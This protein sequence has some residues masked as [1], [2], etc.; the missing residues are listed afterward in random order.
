MTPNKKTRQN[1]KIFKTCLLIFLSSLK[2]N[3]VS[4]AGSDVAHASASA[5]AVADTTPS[6][7][8]NPNKPSKKER[9]YAVSFPRNDDFI[10]YTPFEIN[11]NKIHLQNISNCYNCYNILFLLKLDE[12]ENL[13]KNLTTSEKNNK[14]IAT[15]FDETRNKTSTFSVIDGCSALIFPNDENDTESIIKVAIRLI[16]AK[17]LDDEN[18][19]DSSSEFAENN[20][21]VHFK[22]PK[23]LIEGL[24]KN[25]HK[26][27]VEDRYNLIKKYANSI[28]ENSQ[29]HYKAAIRILLEK[30]QLKK[31]RELKENDFSSSDV[32]LTINLSEN[33]NNEK[34]F[35]YVV[36]PHS[37]KKYLIQVHKI[38][39]EDN[40]INLSGI[41]N[42]ISI[43]TLNL[44][45][46]SFEDIEFKNYLQQIGTTQSIENISH[47]LAII[48]HQTP[49][50]KKINIQITDIAL[51][52]AGVQMQNEESKQFIFYE[53]LIFAINKKTY[54]DFDSN[55]IIDIRNFINQT[56]NFDDSNDG[57]LSQAKNFLYLKLKKKFNRSEAMLLDN[58]KLETH[59]NN[60]NLRIGFFKNLWSKIKLFFFKIKLWFKYSKDERNEI[61]KLKP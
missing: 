58:K 33:K 37:T 36:T 55:S 35:I 50:N 53:Y 46:I 10:V 47:N 19:K 43:F 14:K 40:I 26:N 38:K 11:D 27:Q 3:I 5:A 15:M 20:N 42:I 4:S 59:Y 49:L 57:L 52:L 29:S 48:L 51:R 31:I 30:K 25:S 1:I 18:K 61:Y 28:D 45:R 7:S 39:I 22:F 41:Q 54:V 6:I 8:S 16:R 56:L 34:E 9:I 2:I 60:I 24:D 21:R 12:T 13:F 17:E 44:Q 23:F 32:R